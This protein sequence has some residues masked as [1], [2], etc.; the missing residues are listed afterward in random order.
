MSRPPAV[1]GSPAGP[2]G[3]Q[4]RP[5]PVREP[6][7]VEI[8][9]DQGYHPDRLRVPSGVPVRLVFRRLDSDPCTERVVFSSPRLERRLA[10]GTTTVV[11]LP[12]QDAGEIR[13]TCGMGRYRGRIEVSSPRRGWRERLHAVRRR[14]P[15]SG[16]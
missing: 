1:P 3:G 11:D 12:P 8:A 10:P 6:R 5:A 7:L 13:F 9:V 15:S 4:A 14:T 2:A 16:T